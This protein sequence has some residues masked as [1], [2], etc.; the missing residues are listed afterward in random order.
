MTDFKAIKYDIYGIISNINNVHNREEYIHML[1]NDICE[2]FQFNKTHIFILNSN[3][4]IVNLIIPEKLTHTILDMIKTNVFA[5]I[6]NMYLLISDYVFKKYDHDEILAII[7]HEIGH[8]KNS[9]RIEKDILNNVNGI[10]SKV[11]I[12][13]E[14]FADSF[15]AKLGYKKALIRFLNRY[16]GIDIGLRINKLVNLK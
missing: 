9:E 12:D 7:L 13:H 1:E 5:S 14:Y 11:D 2:I 10:V 4:P 8:L 15:A 3:V 6:P 16:D